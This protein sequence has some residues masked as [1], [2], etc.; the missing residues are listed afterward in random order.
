MGH[1]SRLAQQAWQHC[2]EA[3]NSFLQQG[4]LRNAAVA[5]SDALE[6]CT[7]PTVRAN[8][9]YARAFVYWTA[10]HFETAINDLTSAIKMNDEFADAYNL[11]GVCH[12][13]TKQ[14]EEA[15]SDFSNAIDCG[16]NDASPFLNRAKTFLELGLLEFALPDLIDAIERDE[17]HSSW[18][19][20]LVKEL[21]TEV[22]LNRCSVTYANRALALHYS[23]CTAPAQEDLQLAMSLARTPQETAFVLARLSQIR[24]CDGD[25]MGAITECSTAVQ[26]DPECTLAFY[27]AGL[28][29]VGLGH[30][31]EAQTT[32]VHCQTVAGQQNF[33]GSD[34]YL[35]A[36]QTEIAELALPS[37]NAAV[38]VA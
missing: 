2:Y 35:R 29:Y 18:L 14:V 13:R 9:F 16:L 36:C 7:D 6:A 12:A 4:N 22:T 25:F 20:K 21:T 8:I 5:F 15:I 26:F 17:H 33:V 38:A 1:K 31:D 37:A 28:A 23:G 19:Q 30:V 32:F 34:H 24:I 10:N 27:M 3:G 11:R